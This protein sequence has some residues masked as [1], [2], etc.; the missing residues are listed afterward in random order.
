GEAGPVP[1][2]PKA[3]PARPRSRQKRARRANVGGGLGTNG[4]RSERR[5]SVPPLLPRDFGEFP[6]CADAR[7]AAGPE[8]HGP[9]RLRPGP[10]NGRA[11]RAAEEPI[12]E[13]GWPI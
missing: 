8:P 1:V 9:I 3:G 5:F 11:G 13:T 10:P 4:A 12:R 2:P 6:R 7:R